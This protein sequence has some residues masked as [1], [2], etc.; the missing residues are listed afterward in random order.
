MAYDWTFPGRAEMVKSALDVLNV[1][2]AVP[3]AQVRNIFNMYTDSQMVKAAK[4]V[5][6]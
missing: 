1:C 6:K 3:K 4:R 2:A 5:L